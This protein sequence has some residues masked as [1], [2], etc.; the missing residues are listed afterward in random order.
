MVLQA[1]YTNANITLTNLVGWETGAQRLRLRLRLRRR[2]RRRREIRLP[3]AAMLVS[4]APALCTT[5]LS[6]KIMEHIRL[7]D[8]APTALVNTVLD[9]ISQ[10]KLK[11]LKNPYKNL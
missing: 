2:R 11:K 6:K 4:T 3:T 10:M 9:P 7:L 1:L 8:V 5:Q